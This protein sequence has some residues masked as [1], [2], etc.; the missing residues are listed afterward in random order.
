MQLELILL[1][2]W[3]T[4]IGVEKELLE[5]LSLDLQAIHIE[6]VLSLTQD[7]LIRCSHRYIYIYI[8]L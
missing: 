3:V 2:E 8:V 7:E 4:L 1:W 6:T 5:I